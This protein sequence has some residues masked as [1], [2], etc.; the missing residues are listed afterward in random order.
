MAAIQ[1]NATA[2]WI[3][4]EYIDD[5][6]KIDIPLL[7]DEQLQEINEKVHE[8]IEKDSIVDISYWEDGYIHTLQCFINKINI[9]E[10]IMIIKQVDNKGMLKITLNSIVSVE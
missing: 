8:K 3:L 6:N 7:S 4:E 9:L 2:I 5:Q 10:G 1:N